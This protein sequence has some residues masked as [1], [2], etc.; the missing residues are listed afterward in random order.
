MPLLSISKYKELENKCITELSNRK[1][2][3]DSIL[4]SEEDEED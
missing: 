3:I 4:E 2:E 1:I